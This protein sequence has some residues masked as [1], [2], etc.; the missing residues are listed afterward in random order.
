M[1][2]F[3]L[4]N[5]IWCK[6]FSYL[7]LASKKN[8]TAT[9]KLWFRLIREDP[10]LSGY[11]VISWYNMEEALET[12]QWNWSNWPALKTFE[13][14]KLF[15]LE[16]NLVCTR[17]CIQSV[18]KKLSLKDQCP[19]SLEE[20][21]FYVDLT[22]EIQTYGQSL[23][24][25]QPHTD[26]IFGFDENLDSIQKWNEYELNM[27]ALKKLKS[28]GYRAGGTTEAMR[29]LL[30][31]GT[32]GEQTVAG[33]EAALSNDLLLLNEN[34]HFQRFRRICNNCPLDLEYTELAEYLDFALSEERFRED[35]AYSTTSLDDLFPGRRFRQNWSLARF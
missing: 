17:I 7:T 26:Q 8:A 3:N 6:I 33:L 5:E 35:F 25:W 13:L 18:I 27:N 14:N 11:I 15:L 21:L 12:L 22:P 24:M 31:E 9:C 32:L 30:Q 16:Q 4:P 29:Q 10:N 20:V 19:P 28:M 34:P 2:D 23:L 1:S